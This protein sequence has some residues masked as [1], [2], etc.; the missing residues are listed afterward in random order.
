MSGVFGKTAVDHE[1]RP[2]RL[3]CRKI[4]PSQGKSPTVKHD[5]KDHEV[6]RDGKRKL[7]LTGPWAGVGD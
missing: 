5:R 4:S 6:V 7:A 1:K 3:D 2:G